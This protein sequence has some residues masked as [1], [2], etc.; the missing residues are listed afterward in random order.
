MLALLPHLLSLKENI[1]SPV[2]LEW[3]ITRR[4]RRGIWSSWTVQVILDREH[5]D[6]ALAKDYF[7]EESRDE[8]AC[9][10]VSKWGTTFAKLPS[11]LYLMQIRRINQR[12]SCPEE[13]VGGTNR[14]CR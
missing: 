6:C 8:E 7:Y 11:S 14:G 3:K 10:L 13:G 12:Q 1:K 5:E 9:R 4:E 2:G